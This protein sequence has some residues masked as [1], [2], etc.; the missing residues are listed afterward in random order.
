MSR[1]V[2]ADRDDQPVAGGR[3]IVG[4]VTSSLGLDDLEA[5]VGAG[6]RAVAPE[7]AGMAAAG[8]R[9]DD[10]ERPRIRLAFS[11]SRV[12]CRCNAGTEANRFSARS[13]CTNQSVISF[14]YRSPSKS[15]T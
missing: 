1:A 5:E 8:R 14:A 9:V 11:T 7:A 15:R 3:R 10:Y 13:R 2:A 4:S 12:I 6:C